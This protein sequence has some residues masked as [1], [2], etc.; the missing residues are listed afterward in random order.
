MK[1]LTIGMKLIVGFGIVLF[2]MLLS[3]GL[4]IYS[5]ST[6]TAQIDLYGQYTV[7]NSNSLSSM[8]RGLVSAQRY[9]LRAFVA[10]DA[11]EIGN[12][13]AQ[14]EKDG[15]AILETLELYAGNQRNSNRDQQIGIVRKN[16]EQAAS[17]RREIARLLSNRS[18]DNMQKAQS[19][20]YDDYIPIFNTTEDIFFGFAESAGENE[21]AQKAEADKATNLAWVML[22][23]VAV[24]SILITV[25]VVFTIRKSILSPVKEIE[26][27]YAQMAKGNM[28]AQITYDSRDE[29]GSMARSIKTTNALLAGYINDI[30]EKLGQM[31][32]GN[33]RVS[34]DMDYIGDF[35]AIKKAMQN[36]ASALNHTLLTINT[37]AEQV[38]TG[39][40][41]VA[42]GAQALATGS[43]E[44]ASSVEELSVSITKIAEQAGENSTNVKLAAQYV[45]QTGTFVKDGS[46]RMKQLTEAMSNIGS[47]SGQIAS[48]TKVIEDIAFQTNIL[49]LTPPSKR[50]A[51]ATPGRG[52]PLWPM[53]CA[54]WPPNRRRRQ[55]KPLT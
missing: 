9:L 12:E 14:A 15:Q 53:R 51:P 22:I 4:S 20:F 8:R 50:P 34:V 36:T 31:S 49:A 42:S 37:A 47:A 54:T 29:L 26:G 27:V 13:L 55:S 35:A 1:N 16:L 19:L 48:I 39:A 45:N 33:M 10:E 44:Q 18:E 17:I 21:K 5:I 30:S 2:I 46:E 11:K 3:I 23:A 43:T 25:A 40:S 32:Q 7:P 38:S 6:V 41:Q 52:L 24:A 28:Q